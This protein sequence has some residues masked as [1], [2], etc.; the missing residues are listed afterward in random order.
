MDYAGLSLAEIAATYL[1][2]GLGYYI[3]KSSAASI[4]LLP[5]EL[6]PSSVSIGN[7]ALAGAVWCLFHESGSSEMQ[8]IANVCQTVELNDTVLFSE[9]F[10]EHMMFPCEGEYG[11]K[12]P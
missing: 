6:L 10:M 2:G 7:S 8:M 3:N 11:V 4:G 5:C 12:L 9:L 1:A